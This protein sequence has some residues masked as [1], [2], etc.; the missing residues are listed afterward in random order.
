MAQHGDAKP[1]LK[2]RLLEELFKFWWVAG[3]LF[4]CFTVLLL[5]K[6]AILRQHDIDFVPF[7]IA[8][9]KALVLGKFI[10][11]GDMLPLAR[12]TGPTLL[13]RVARRTLAVFVILL[14]FTLAEELVTGLLHGETLAA[15]VHERLSRDAVE[16]FAGPLLML[17]IL[18]PL[19]LASELRK[20]LGDE[21]LR[22]LM[23]GRNV[24][25]T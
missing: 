13:H 14:L 21:R 23:L 22:A 1:P 2:T 10:L 16:T 15:V 24:D 5:W 3:Y 25:A 7:G 12:R 19:M 11:I 18:V 6:A 17:L 20:T 4:V 8:L 9:I